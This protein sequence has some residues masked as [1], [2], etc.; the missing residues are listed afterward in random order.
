MMRFEGGAVGE[1]V[2]S[3][4]A[5]RGSGHRIEIYGEEGSLILENPGPDYMRESRLL[6]RPNAWE[7]VGISTSEEDSWHDGRVLPASRLTKRFTDWALRGSLASLALPLACVSRRSSMLPGIPTTPVGG[8]TLPGTHQTDRHGA[9]TFSHYGG[10]GFIGATLVLRLVKEISLNLNRVSRPSGGAEPRLQV[11]DAIDGAAA[12]ASTSD[13][14]KVTVL[15]AEG[16]RAKGSNEI[17]MRKLRMETIRAKWLPL[18]TWC[19]KNDRR[20]AFGSC[21][22]ARRHRRNSALL[23]GLFERQAYGA[24]PYSRRRKS[25]RFYQSRSP[26]CR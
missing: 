20:T 19:H 12:K 18:V 16:A 21:A 25:G 7:P 14:G 8:S 9:Q 13:P 6:R 15:L 17:R 10:T 23:A 26:T 4:A 2:M 3:A 22:V 24:W 5:Y 1:L 11:L